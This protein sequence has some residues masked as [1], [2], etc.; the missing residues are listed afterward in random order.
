MVVYYRAFGLIA[1]IGLLVNVVLI[2]GLLSLL[3]AALTL[4]V[5][6]ASC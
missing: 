5:L 2:V 6:P 4:P 1:N 3:Q